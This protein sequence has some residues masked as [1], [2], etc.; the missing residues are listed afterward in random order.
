MVQGGGGSKLGDYRTR[1]SMPGCSGKIGREDLSVNLNLNK[2]NY[3]FLNNKMSFGKVIYD[4]L[5]QYSKLER[6]LFEINNTEKN[7]CRYI[8]FVHNK[9]VQEKVK[10][11]IREQEMNELK[12]KIDELDEKIFILEKKKENK[13]L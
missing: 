10:S 11:N 4:K 3:Y 2:N 12:L 8:S 13:R 1:K 7:F 9:Y 6:E 5:L